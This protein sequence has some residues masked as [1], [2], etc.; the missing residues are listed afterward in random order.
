M[1]AL[2]G[3]SD[4]QGKIIE[5][6]NSFAIQLRVQKGEESSKEPEYIFDTE[7]LKKMLKFHK[8]VN[9]MENILGVYISSN[10]VDS[11]G[12]VI[13]KYFLDL[14]SE[15]SFFRS[16]L[17]SPIIMLF[18]PSLNNNKLDIKVSAKLKS[19]TEFLCLDLEYLFILL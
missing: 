17:K 16:P 19:L 7:Y 14:F 11:Q 2:L 1:G 12:M 3:T 18:D 6:S 4:A 8:T 13:V 15:K 10:S 5:I 9:D